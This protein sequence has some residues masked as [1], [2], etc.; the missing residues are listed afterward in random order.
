MDL[1]R[2]VVVLLHI[3]GFAVTFGAW[4]TEA[5]ARRFRITRPM[6][7]GLVLS[8][9]TGLILSAPWPAGIELNY[10]KIGTKLIILVILGGVLGM[11]SAR[12]KRTGEP[13]PGAMFWAVGVLSFL[14]ATVAVLW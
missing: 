3:V 1:L 8:L 2:N 14:G 12:Q 5:V 4:V 7:Y 6:D 9:V 11:G 10:P 13:V